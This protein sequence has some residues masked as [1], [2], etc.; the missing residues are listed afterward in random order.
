MGALFCPQCG[1]ALQTSDRF[2]GTC[3]AK[4]PQVQEQPAEVATV[5]S[6]SPPPAVPVADV[7]DKTEKRSFF[8]SPL[9]LVW[10]GLL[11]V[12]MA[13]L[14]MRPVPDTPAAGK[15]IEVQH[16]GWIF[17]APSTDYA[18]LPALMAKTD[19]SPDTEMGQLV[20]V[21]QPGKPS[22]DYFALLVAPMFKHGDSVEATLAIEGSDAALS[23]DMRD[24]YASKGSKRPGIDWDASIL[25]APIEMEDLGELIQAKALLVSAAG[26]NWRL[27]G[28]K[29]LKQSGQGFLSDCEG[30]K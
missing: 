3:G 27:A 25:F 28:G 18:D 15:P 14:F 19:F 22:S 17:T 9:V 24:L 30:R 10:F 7:P 6:P 1:A 4:V 21:C 26:Q 23:L 12:L 2:C 20:F 11:L 8:T 5:P 13:V 29:T 16:N